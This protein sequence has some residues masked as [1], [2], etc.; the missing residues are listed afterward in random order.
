MKT[1][2]QRSAFDADQAEIRAIR[3]GKSSV[4]VGT[5]DEMMS[6]EAL[7]EGDAQTQAAPFKV[8]IWEREGTGLT[9]LV[10]ETIAVVRER[11]QLLGGLYPFT[12]DRSGLTHVP[13]S[14][15]LYEFCLAT[16][17]AVSNAT[18]SYRRLVRHFERVVKQLLVA[19]CG[20]DAKGC[21]FGWPSEAYFENATTNVRD[22]IDLMRKLCG[23]DS[24]EWAVS[25]SKYMEKMIEDAKDAKID[26]VIR[27]PLFDSRPGGLTL[28][29]QCGCGKNDVIEGSTKHEELN[30]NWL[31][32]FF[33]RVCVPN[34]V[35]V[36]ATSQ[37]VACPT[38]V[39]AKQKSGQ[40]LMFDRIRLVKLA[41]AFPV[42]TGKETKWM[43]LL[44]NYVATNPPKPEPVA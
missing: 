10:G 6:G 13:S 17:D 38:Q 3:E 8:P 44:T 11:Q 25:T 28:I 37:H 5:Y 16:S 9:S 18:K 33:D 29:G 21:R 40:S 36:F 1:F 30:G 39:F 31:D 4:T 26:F 2:R 34:P 41:N 32:M 19:F 27:H 42:D 22:R 24:D 15:G 43:H 35:Y 12:V 14:L 23:F 7:D 20:P